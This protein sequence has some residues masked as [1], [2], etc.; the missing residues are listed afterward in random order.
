MN[1]HLYNMNLPLAQGK[2]ST[3]L[4]CPQQRRAGQVGRYP[5]RFIFCADTVCLHSVTLC[6]FLKTTGLKRNQVPSKSLKFVIRRLDSMRYGTSLLSRGL[7]T[8][9]PFYC[10]VHRIFRYP[11]LYIKIIQHLSPISC[12]SDDAMRSQEREA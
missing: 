7:E 11:L 2:K 12:F 9:L 10:Q 1:L 4:M 3:W 5:C 8:Y 6:L